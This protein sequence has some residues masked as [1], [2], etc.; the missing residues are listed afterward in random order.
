MADKT[1]DLLIEI[2]CEEIPA[3]MQAQSA[4]DLARLFAEAL[5]AANLLT[6]R[7]TALSRRA[8]LR[9]MSMSWWRNSKTAFWKNAA[10]A[11]M[12]ETGN[13]RLFKIYRP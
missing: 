11:L 2:I 3:R 4:S 6:V 5:A 13:Q 8:I 9:F 7:C 10:H 1:A 12:L